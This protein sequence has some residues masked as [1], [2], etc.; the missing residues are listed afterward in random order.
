MLIF[1]KEP[2]GT[3][4]TLLAMVLGFIPFV[5]IMA[6]AAFP[7]KEV[8]VYANGEVTKKLKNS[9]SKHL[10][11]SYNERYNFVL[12]VT[13]NGYLFFSTIALGISLLQVSSTE[14]FVLGIVVLSVEGI[15]QFLVLGMTMAHWH[16][17]FEKAALDLF[18][19]GMD[20]P[21][22]IWY[23]SFY[24]NPRTKFAVIAKILVESLSNSLNNYG[25]YVERYLYFE[26]PVE[27]QKPT[28]NLDQR[29]MISTSKVQPA[30][31][32][33]NGV[34]ELGSQPPYVLKDEIKKMYIYR[35]NYYDNANLANV[36]FY[37]SLYIL[38]CPFIGLWEI[39]NA[40]KSSLTRDFGWFLN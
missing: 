13:W 30:D 28:N 10:S 27:E 2:L 14:E 21:L 29:D 18:F 37:H 1:Y 5:I 16:D 26:E 24:C 20:I 17:S 25:A 39:A 6:D 23:L 3:I 7:E 33:T 11:I 12:R 8:F 4:A 38:L 36:L 40:T 15:P 19:N 22:C 32:T 34:P 31:V 35:T 9:W